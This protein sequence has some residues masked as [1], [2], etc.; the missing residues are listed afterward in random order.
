MKQWLYDG[1]FRFKAWALFNYW[2][3]VSNDD[4]E[5]VLKLYLLKRW[6]R[7]AMK[8][9]IKQL[10]THPLSKE[11]ADMTGSSWYVGNIAADWSDRIDAKILKHNQESNID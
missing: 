10:D 1:W 3:R 2:K 8:A 7:R 9:Y 6:E 5:E 11:T 4:Y